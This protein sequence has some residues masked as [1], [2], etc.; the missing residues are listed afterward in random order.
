MGNKVDY[1]ELPQFIFH[2]NIL[3]TAQ[4][5]VV[6]TTEDLRVCPGINDPTMINTAERKEHVSLYQVDS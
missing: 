1:G 6:K 4:Q 2:P 5:M 3:K